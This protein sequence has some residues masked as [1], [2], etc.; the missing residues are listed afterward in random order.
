VPRVGHGVA[1]AAWVIVF[2]GMV[3][4]FLATGVRQAAGARPV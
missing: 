1:S 2:I 3:R 4:A